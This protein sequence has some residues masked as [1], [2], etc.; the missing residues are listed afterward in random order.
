MHQ[1]QQQQ[2][3]NGNAWGDVLAKK[4]WN[5]GGVFMCAKLTNDFRGYGYNLSIWPEAELFQSGVENHT[6]TCSPTEL[7]CVGVLMSWTIKYTL[8]DQ[9]NIN[10]ISAGT[11]CGW[12]PSGT[13]C[14]GS[15]EWIWLCGRWCFAVFLAF[16]SAEFISKVFYGLDIGIVGFG[17]LA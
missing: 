17:S 6:H 14:R 12:E 7:E 9:K 16:T 2:Q 3:Q 8:S 11:H 1:Q 5:A 15:H 13:P 4:P 10:L